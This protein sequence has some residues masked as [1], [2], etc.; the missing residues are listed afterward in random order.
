MSSSVLR[1]GGNGSVQLADGNANFVGAGFNGLSFSCTPIELLSN[2]GTEK[3]LSTASGFFWLRDGQPYLV[4]NWHVVSGRNPFTGELNKKAYMPSRIRFYGF[5]LTIHNGVVN[6]KRIQWTLEWEEDMHAALTEPPKID[7]QTLDIWGVPIPIGCVF[8]KDPTRLGFHGSV[9]AT[10][11]LN[12]HIGPRIVTNVGDDCFILGYPLQ[13]YEGLMP[14]VWKRG[15]IASETPLGVGGKPIFLVDAAT[16]PGMSGSP[17]IRKV[18][19]LTANNSDLNALQEY[20]SYELIGV[21]AGRLENAALSSVQLGYGWYRNMI[22]SAID[23][24][25]YTSPK[26]VMDGANLAS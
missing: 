4:T 10:C 7:G 3:V 18:I 20:S 17:I 23:H 9:E 5:T 13:N 22:D 12:D 14:P 26:A 21:Y 2:D 1:Y 24:Y 6:F 15:S 8:G 25:K 16:T 11:Y 19:T